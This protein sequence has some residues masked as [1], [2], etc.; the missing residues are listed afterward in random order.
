VLTRAYHYDLP[1]DRIA[2][3]PAADRDQSRLLILH[4]DGSPMEHHTFSAFPNLLRPGDLLIL[5]DS[6]VIPARLRGVKESSGGAIEILLLEE[7]APL[8]WWVMLRPGKRVRPGTRLRFLARDGALSD[9]NAEVMEKNGEGWCRLRFQGVT[10][11]RQVLPLLG[12]I[13]LP[14]YLSRASSG[15]EPPDRIRYQTVYA[16]TDGSVAAPTAGLHFTPALLEVIRGRGVDIQFV[17][18]HVG[19]GTFAPVKSGNLEE[20]RMHEEWYEVPPATADAWQRARTEGR[21][22]VAVGTTSVRVL[23]SVG[24]ANSGQV[25]AGSGRTRIFLHPPQTFTAVDA[26]LT[27][28]HLPESTLLMLVSAFVAP[29]ENERGRLQVLEAYREAI[30]L[31]YRFFSYGDAMFIA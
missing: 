17:T 13:P 2:Q 14:P 7:N 11:L 23:E 4:R 21:R 29:G 24:R 26:L 20:H 1:A 27:N 30:R 9:L 19:H 8:D 16:R 3:Y 22:V 25:V 6:R 10:D 28:F 12:E 15:E 18:L 5:N 31:G